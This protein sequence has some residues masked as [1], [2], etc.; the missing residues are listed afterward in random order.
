MKHLEYPHTI[1]PHRVILPLYRVGT[2]CGAVYY[3]RLST[4][5]HAAKREGVPLAEWVPPEFR[6]PEREAWEEVR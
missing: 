6:G 1:G 3:N 2:R 4:A 5:R